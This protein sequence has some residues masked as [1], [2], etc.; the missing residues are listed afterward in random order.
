MPARHGGTPPLTICIMHL[1]SGRAPAAKAKRPHETTTC[2]G[3]RTAGDIVE[4]MT[5]SRDTSLYRTCGL[6]VIAGAMSA[7]SNASESPP[8]THAARRR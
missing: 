7:T 3:S 6:L 1:S 5:P 2:E 4:N 8:V